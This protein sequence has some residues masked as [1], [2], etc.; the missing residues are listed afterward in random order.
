MK[1]FTPDILQR[2]RILQAREVGEVHPDDNGGELGLHAALGL[3]LWDSTL[4]DVRFGIEPPPGM[5]ARSQKDYRQVIE[6]RRALE[7]ACSAV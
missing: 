5:D 1:T 3:K 2:F 6:L 7:R 4:S